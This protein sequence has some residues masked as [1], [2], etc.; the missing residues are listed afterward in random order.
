VFASS[1]YKAYPRVPKS[2][3]DEYEKQAKVL[4]K[5]QDAQRKFLDDASKLY[6]QML[7]AQS[8]AY[9]MASWKVATQKG[10]TLESVAEE[11][12]LD[13]EILGRWNKFLAKKPD[14]YPDLK[15][16]Q[17][18]IAKKGKEADAKKLAQEFVARVTTVKERYDR[19]TK[20][21]EFALAQ[22]KGTPMADED[23]DAEK[24]PDTAKEPFD[25]LPNGGKRRLN[26][27]QIDLKG[28][29]REETLLYQD[30]FERDVPELA[31]EGE[32][33]DD[34][35]PGRQR[36][37]GLLKLTDNALERRLSGDLRIHLDRINADVEAFRKQMPKQYP[38]VYGIED[39]KNPA[40]LRVFVRGNPYAFGDA[41]PRSFPSILNHGEATTFAKGSGR[42]EMADA[43]A[44]SP[45]AARVIVN[46]LWR[47]N[48][49]R[50]IVDTPSNFGLSGD[51]PTHPELLDFLATQFIADGMSWKKLTKQ[52]VMSHTY[53]LSAAPVA[54]NQQKDASNTLYWRANRRRVE[55]EG[56]WDLLL[57]ASGTLDTTSVGGPS[58]DLDEKMKRRGVYAKVSRM[59]PSDFQATFDLPP[60]TISAEKR[61]IT[62]VPQQRLFFLNNS[63]V[64]LKA[65]EIVKKLNDLPTPDAKVKKAYELI[66]QRVPTPDELSLGVAFIQ[67]PAAKPKD[68]EG[69]KAEDAKDA[70]AKDS[71]EDSKDGKDGKGG[72]KPVKLPDSPLR[73]FAWALISSNEFLFID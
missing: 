40:D 24:D 36:K 28:L 64:Q 44:K 15:A 45:I 55:S 37:P 58:E 5:K 12:K 33:D 63:L 6:T 30:V 73:S 1:R 60:A 48:M 21:N 7:F 41:A 43:I 71:D 69:T 42:L 22:V 61:Y 26:A 65:E 56:V 39:A 52:I 51:K 72:K 68:G 49:G 13:P 34:A 35:M 59:Y 19:L 47:W 53:Q 70:D 2:V 3:V 54:A 9:L 10:A 4:K 66:Y 8:E 31:N 38:F 50:G 17:G 25:P 14:N 23:A 46:R 27:Y 67:K 11:A 29:D 32:G 16:W 57:Q 62:N 18:M 20:E